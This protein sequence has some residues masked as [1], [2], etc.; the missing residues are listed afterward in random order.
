ML[1]QVQT[2]A[3]AV[4]ASI[5]VVAIVL[6]VAFTSDE[7]FEA[8][9]LWLVGAQVAAAVLVHLVVEAIGYRTAA[10]HTETTEPEARALSARAFTTGTIVRLSLCESIAL[11]SVVAGFLVGSGGYV[12]ILTG[13]AISLALLAVHAWPR[14]STVDRVATALERDGA[15]SYLREQLGLGLSGPIKQL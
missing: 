4:I 13:A 2:L 5:V 15:R 10:L 11:G 12:G 14:A 3:G 8:P 9:P 1:R 7:R 6:G